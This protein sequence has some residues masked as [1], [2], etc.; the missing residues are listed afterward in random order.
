MVMIF[1]SVEDKKTFSNLSFMHNNFK[2]TLPFTLILLWEYMFKASIPSKYLSILHNN[3]WLE[4]T[5]NTLW[6]EF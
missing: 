2:I 4:W 5:L 1:G 3:M 6:V